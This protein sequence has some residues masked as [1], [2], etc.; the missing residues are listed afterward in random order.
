MARSAY[1]IF[2]PV[3]TCRREIAA[4]LV[5]LTERTGEGAFTGGQIYAEMVSAGTEYSK[6]AVLKTL[7]RMK[8]APIRAPG[9]GGKV[10]VPPGQNDLKVP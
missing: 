3:S 7:Q 9:A 10:R 5:G 8:E 4:A 1:P 6:S 2:I